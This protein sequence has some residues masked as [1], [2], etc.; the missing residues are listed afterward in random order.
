MIVQDIIL[1]PLWIK[2]NFIS[3]C[4]E[5]LSSSIIFVKDNIRVIRRPESQ[6]KLVVFRRW[7]GVKVNVSSLLC[8]FWTGKDHDKTATLNLLAAE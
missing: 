2:Y 7:Y 1:S 6:T 8:I 3:H 4:G 5:I